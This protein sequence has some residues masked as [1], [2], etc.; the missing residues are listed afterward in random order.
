MKKPTS[1]PFEMSKKDKEYG[2]KENSPKDK[3]M[4]KKQMPKKK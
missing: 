1:K 2:A 4:D 3:A